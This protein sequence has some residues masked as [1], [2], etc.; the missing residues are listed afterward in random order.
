MAGDAYTEL[1][2]EIDELNP[3]RPPGGTP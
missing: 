1:E 2:A 3:A